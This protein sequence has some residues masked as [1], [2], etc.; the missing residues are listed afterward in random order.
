MYDD[1][2]LCDEDG[3]QG[4]DFSD[5]KEYFAA[6][7]APVTPAAI[8]SFAVSISVR[9][10][11]HFPACEPRLLMGFL[12]ECSCHTPLMVAGQEVWFCKIPE[13]LSHCIPL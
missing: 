11:I 4:S 12:S 6:M 5:L 3:L 10:V 1:T 8:D 2:G 7:F 13:D 9:L